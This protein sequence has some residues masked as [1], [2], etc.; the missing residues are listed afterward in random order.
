MVNG[1][2]NRS[3]ICTWQPTCTLKENL[4]E[5]ISKPMKDLKGLVLFLLLYLLKSQDDGQGSDTEH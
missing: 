3:I 4:D 5:N 2:K 1:G